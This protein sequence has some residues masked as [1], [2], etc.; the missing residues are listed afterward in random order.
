MKYLLAC[1]CSLIISTIYAQP[2]PIDTDRPDQTESVN[3]VPKGWTQVEAGF[4]YEA[5]SNDH[6]YVLPDILS[7]YGLSKRIELR[8]ITTL[9]T[10]SESNLYKNKLIIQPIEIGSKIFLFDEKKL[11]PRTSFIFHIGIPAFS[12]KAVRPSMVAPNFRFTMQHTL[13]PEVSLGYNL[14]AEWDGESSIPSYI[15]TFTVGKTFYKK[16]YGYIEA[17]GN[18]RKNELPLHS[19]DGG[20]AYLINNNVKVDISSGTGI[21]N[22]SSNWYIAL[23][24]SARFK[25]SKK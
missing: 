25:T 7:K 4:N 6:S 21:A 20:I 16:W 9:Q 10:I 14:G 22:N 11:I 3:L 13:S 19:V 12:S 1:L 23:G 18:M 17:F 8:L 5:E 2:D 15:Y 24:V